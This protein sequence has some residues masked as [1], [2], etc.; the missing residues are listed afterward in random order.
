MLP[1]L[2][3]PLEVYQALSASG[4]QSRLE[5]AALHGLTPLVGRGHEVAFLTERWI[6]VTEGL[7]QVVLLT[8]E[9]GIGKSRLVQVLK[10]HVADEGHAWLECQG[11]PYTQHTAFSPLIALLEPAVL[12]GDREAA[13]PQR[14]ATL[15]ACVRHYDLPLTQV[16]PFLA[17]LLSL[18]LSADYAPLPLSPEQQKQHILQAL[19]T[20]LLRMAAQQ[21]LLLVMEDLHW[22]DPSTLEWLSLLVDQGPTTRLL[23][24]CT[25]RPDFQVPWRGRAHCTQLTL[26]RLPA[27]QATALVQHMAHGKTLPIDV[28]TQLVAKTDG[29]PLFVEEM[30]KTV[31]ASELLQEHEAHYT[32]TGPLP[33]L[34]IPI[35]C[36]MRCL[37]DWTAWGPP[38]GWRNLGPR[39][40]GNLRMTCCWPLPRGRRR[41]YSAGCN[42]WWPPS[43]STSAGCRHRQRMSSSMP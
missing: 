10:A 38:R 26:T 35:R 5:A 20:L 32:L 13:P 31:L 1:G 9:A 14:L 18:P 33:P 41:Q 34:A 7:G 11:S 23:A 22:V 29:V 37:R 36:M 40:G 19:L 12:H 6:Y 25:S 27:R 43:S 21:P 2:A 15:E 8:G 17:A 30:T 3:Q 4:V 16:V 24:V 42:S 39:S 28:V